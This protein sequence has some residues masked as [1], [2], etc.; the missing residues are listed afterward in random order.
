M[1]AHNLLSVCLSIAAFICTHVNAQDHTRTRTLM[2][3]WAEAEDCAAQLVVVVKAD[4]TAWTHAIGLADIKGKVP[5]GD[6]TRIPLGSLTQDL[7]AV[8][9]ELAGE[10]HDL[11]LS[12][13]VGESLGSGG[14]VSE[15]VRATSWL[16]LYRGN[17]GLACFFAYTRDVKT[18]R[19]LV[20]VLDEN[21]FPRGS[22]PVH[23]PGE[24]HAGFAVLQRAFERTVE[25]PW[26]VYL[27][28]VIGTS[29]G[30]RS[31]IDASALHSTGDL[32]IYEN[33]G[34]AT[35]RGAL[36][37][38]VA[39]AYNAWTTAADMPAYLKHLLASLKNPESNRF[40]RWDKA[41]EP[42]W[43]ADYIYRR[44]SGSGA[45]CEVNVFKEYGLAMFW[46]SN[47]RD[48]SALRELRVTL[49][50]DQLGKPISSDE[51]DR[52]LGGGFGGRFRSPLDKK[53]RRR[54]RG[55]LQVG[56]P[57]SRGLPIEI[58]IS[59]FGVHLRDKSGAVSEYKLRNDEGHLEGKVHL[60]DGGWV[61]LSVN[62]E[63]ET[64]RGLAIWHH[65]DLLCLPYEVS[66]AIAPKDSELYPLVKRK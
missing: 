19:P 55:K 12:L 5:F 56:H 9:L 4:G 39:V 32:Q 51:G 66:F 31:T 65:G 33:D 15:P 14:P 45:P 27:K 60:K 24:S 6:W 1:T 57:Q 42:R 18:L 47:R 37:G 46:F 61:E 43:E 25:M 41:S 28:K 64:L 10:S 7:F 49:L 11:D 3:K 38:E 2:D 48:W 35:G 52:G 34:A 22:I 29:I 63:E 58:V 54:W 13:A 26:P 23:W 8:G 53:M 44:S 50:E 21:V 20:T 40:L 17:S 59:F 36:F 62:R 16:D 30:M